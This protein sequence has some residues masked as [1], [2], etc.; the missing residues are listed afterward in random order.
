MEIVPVESFSIGDRSERAQRTP[1]RRNNLVMRMGS[2]GSNSNHMMVRS[3]SSGRSI[4]GMFGVTNS[5][6]SLSGLTEEE[7]DIDWDNWNGWD[8]TPIRHFPRKESVNKFKGSL[9]VVG[10]V[11]KGMG[12]GGLAAGMGGM[13]GGG[14]GGVV[15]GEVG[16]IG[17]EGVVVRKESDGELRK[18]REEKDKLEKMWEGLSKRKR[19]KLEKKYQKKE[20]KER[21]QRAKLEKKERK[22]RAKLEKKKGKK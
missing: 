20:R 5:E 2:N 9:S 8:G 14:N 22:Q 6:L 10:E 4:G 3:T 11:R 15:R 1:S 19:R 21:K 18:I 7:Q 13:G 17:K 16:V 12:V